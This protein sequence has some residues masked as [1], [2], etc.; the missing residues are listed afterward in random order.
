MQGKAHAVDVSR[1][2]LPPRVAVGAVRDLCERVLDIVVEGSVL[3]E[4]Q[5]VAIGVTKLTKE[6]TS[7]Y[8]LVM[9]AVVEF[10]LYVPPAWP[11]S[12]PPVM[13]TEQAQ[14]LFS[15]MAPSIVPEYTP[16]NE[17]HVG[18]EASEHPPLETQ[19]TPPAVRRDAASLCVSLVPER[20]IRSALATAAAARV[21]KMVVNCSL[22]VSY[23]LLLV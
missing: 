21:A 22:W 2:G 23:E 16:V 9:L 7:A 12:V 17:V 5:L 18:L 19:L 14:A 1:G 4:V 6:Y 8:T 3:G 11:V 10:Y 20:S 15:V 13:V